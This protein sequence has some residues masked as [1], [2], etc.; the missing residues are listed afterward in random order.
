MQYYY[1]EI[2]PTWRPKYRLHPVAEA[3]F[4]LLTFGW[5][6]PYLFGAWRFF[7]RTGAHDLNA[8]AAVSLTWIVA[9]SWRSFAGRFPTLA[10]WLLAAFILGAIVAA[11]A[12]SPF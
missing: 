10:G 2:Y 11:A 6:L 7:P 9:F 8:A 5:L 4:G 3:I 1:I 12:L